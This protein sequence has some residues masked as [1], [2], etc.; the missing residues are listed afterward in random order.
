MRCR[1]PASWDD[2]VDGGALCHALFGVDHHHEQYGARLRFQCEAPHGG[3]YV[4][5]AYCHVS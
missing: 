4:Q 5:H 2:G 3:R 1:N